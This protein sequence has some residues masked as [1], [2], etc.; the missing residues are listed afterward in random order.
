MSKRSDIWIVPYATHYDE[1]CLSGT[2]ELL[3]NFLK[4]KAPLNTIW[5]ATE[6]QYGTEWI[7]WELRRL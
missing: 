5:V 7:C 1:R 6:W 2:R 4:Q 3:V